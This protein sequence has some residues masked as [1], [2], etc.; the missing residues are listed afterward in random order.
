M[1]GKL[2]GPQAANVRAS[3]TGPV[4]PAIVFIFASELA[5]D[6]RN[7]RRLTVVAQRLGRT[8]HV[9]SRPRIMPAPQPPPE[10]AVTIWEYYH[11]SGP[12]IP[13]ADIA[14]ERHAVVDVEG[15][16]LAATYQ[17]DRQGVLAAQERKP[18][19][20]TEAGVPVARRL[21]VHIDP[22]DVGDAEGAWPTASSIT[23]SLMRSA[24]LAAIESQT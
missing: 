4:R 5:L 14:S 12:G 1:S 24:R 6:G 13:A 11:A 8:M 20:A 22:A 16:A 2:R 15:S 23:W 9:A 10:R 19:P 17:A 21:A 18:Q 7:L 3:S